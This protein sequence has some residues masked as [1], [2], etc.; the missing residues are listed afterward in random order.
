MKFPQISRLAGYVL[1]VSAM[2][3]AVGTWAQASNNVRFSVDV[4]WSTFSDDSQFLDVVGT[5]GPPEVRQWS[6]SETVST[7]HLGVNVHLGENWVIGTNYQ[8]R[9]QSTLEIRRNTTPLVDRINSTTGWSSVFVERQLIS[10]TRYAWHA[11]AG[12]TRAVTKLS[13]RMD[14]VSSSSRIIDVDPIIGT[15]YTV[16]WKNWSMRLTAMRRFADDNATEF[17]ALTFRFGS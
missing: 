17:L 9:K 2:L 13:A 7:P 3:F 5:L 14:G 15:G 4:G 6:V 16:K 10:N 12:A 1:T 8:T 11:T